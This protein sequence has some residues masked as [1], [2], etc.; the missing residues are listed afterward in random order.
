MQPCNWCELSQI[1]FYYV[2]VF[3][4]SGWQ[5]FLEIEAFQSLGL[6]GRTRR[7]GWRWTGRS[8]ILMRIW[9]GRRLQRWRI[10]LL[11]LPLQPRSVPSGSPGCDGL[12]DWS[13]Q[14]VG[15]LKI[16]I[17][18]IPDISSKWCKVVYLR[19]IKVPFDI[20]SLCNAW[21]VWRGLFVHFRHS[22][23]FQDIV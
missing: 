23:S 18:S 9:K 10:Q 8:A 14:I 5:L 15:N 7:G 11:F 6:A 2:L 19:H 17:F 16:K 1:R 12:S 21:E 4:I 3:L 13:H 20:G 22:N